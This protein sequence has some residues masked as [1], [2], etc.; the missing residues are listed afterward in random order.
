MKDF[1]ILFN[2]LRNQILHINIFFSTHLKAFVQSPGT[3]DRLC[4]PCRW[5]PRTGTGRCPP[6]CRGRPGSRRRRGRALR[7]PPASRS[8]RPGGETGS[9]RRGTSRPPW[10]RLARLQPVHRRAR[11]GH[12]ASFSGNRAREE[13]SECPQ[14]F[15]TSAGRRKKNV[16]GALDGDAPTICWRKCSESCPETNTVIFCNCRKLNLKIDE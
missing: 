8:A 5:T 1:I 16:H 12:S 2:R 4:C 13:R 15:S 6:A 14:K 9:R 10:R 7:P 11:A 3:S